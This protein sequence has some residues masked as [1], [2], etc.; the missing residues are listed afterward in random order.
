VATGPVVELKV[1][2]RSPRRHSASLALIGKV[3]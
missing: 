3:T 2:K 1:K